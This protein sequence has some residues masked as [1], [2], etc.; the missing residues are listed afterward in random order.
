MG[1]HDEFDNA[2]AQTAPAAA[3]RKPLV[4]LVKALKNAFRVAG[5]KADPIV[6]DRELDRSIFSSGVERD[7]FFI[8]GVFEG[9]IQKIDQSGDHV[10]SVNQDRWQIGRSLDLQFAAR[11]Y[12]P[13]ADRSNSV[14]DNAR[15]RHL[16]EFERVFIALNAREGEK[17]INEPAETEIFASNKPKI[18]ARRLFAQ[19]RRIEQGI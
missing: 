19:L 15:C 8:S 1:R 9:I 4:H 14:L 10:I 16:L 3:S 2:K 5:Q 13:I 18:F 11:S 12:E 17:V 6:F 7:P